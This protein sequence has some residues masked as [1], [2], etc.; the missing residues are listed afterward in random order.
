MTEEVKERLNVLER[1]RKAPLPLKCLLLSRTT[2][3]G[4]VEDDDSKQDVVINRKRKSP[5]IVTA[6]SG[7]EW[8]REEKGLGDFG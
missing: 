8:V 3:N 7:W 5:R 4:S 2:S 6:K 1:A